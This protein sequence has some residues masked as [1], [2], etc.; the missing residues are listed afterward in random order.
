MGVPDG[1]A[2]FLSACDIF[3]DFPRQD[4]SG[5]TGN[6]GNAAGD[7][8]FAQGSGFLLPAGGRKRLFLGLDH[9]QMPDAPFAQLLAHDPRQRAHGGFGD[10]RHLKS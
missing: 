7:L 9:L 6:E 8:P 5:G 4:Q 2:L 1:Y 3:D 10:I